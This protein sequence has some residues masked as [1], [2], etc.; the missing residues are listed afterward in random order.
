MRQPIDDVAM[1]ICRLKIILFRYPFLCIIST[2]L[3]LI[4]YGFKVSL[5]KWLELL[6]LILEIWAS[7]RVFVAFLSSFRQITKI[8]HWCFCKEIYIGGINYKNWLFSRIRD[9][10]VSIA[11]GYGLDGLD[12]VPGSAKISFSQHL[13]LLWGPPSLLCNGYRELFP[14]R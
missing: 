4:R 5:T 1:K 14:R 6:R 2:M 8:I 12:S 9:C 7:L 3:N 11:T 10:S 13:D